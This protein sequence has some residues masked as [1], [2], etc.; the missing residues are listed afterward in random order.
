MISAAKLLNIKIVIYILVFYI[1]FTNILIANAQYNVIEPEPFRRD[2]I[3]DRS[4]DYDKQSFVDRFTYR[5]TPQFVRAWNKTGEGFR[6][7]GGSVSKDETYTVAQLKK[8][9]FFND[10]F[11][12]AIRFRRDEDFDSRFDRTLFGVGA[13]FFENW[14]FTFLGDVQAKKENIDLHFELTWEEFPRIDKYDYAQRFAKTNLTSNQNKAVGNRARLA[15]VLVDQFYNGKSEDGLYKQKPLTFFGEFQLHFSTTNQLHGWLN[16]NPKTELELYA[17]NSLFQYE[18]F[19]AGVRLAN[20]LNKNVSSIISLSG[21][22]GKQN[23]I[24]LTQNIEE[25]DFERNNIIAEMEFRYRFSPTLLTWLGVRHFYFTEDDIRVTEASDSNQIDRNEN[26]LHFGLVWNIQN[27]LI[28]R[29]GIYLNDIYNTEELSSDV[30]KNTLDNRVTGRLTFPLEIHF[31]QRNAIIVVN[32]TLEW[33][34]DPFGGLNVQVQ[35]E[36]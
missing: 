8:R 16:Y 18:Q 24:S 1:F 36:L 17:D 10:K 35:F 15:L 4:F 27:N 22:K 31:S 11:F 29:P 5:F 7:T 9:W 14:S 13:Q 3:G 32:P 28:F 21:Q 23:R 12:G 20:E 26:M 33:P 2:E 25:Q 19:Q 30:S 6:I 34:G